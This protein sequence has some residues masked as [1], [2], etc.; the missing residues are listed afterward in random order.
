MRNGFDR[1]KHLLPPRPAGSAAL[2]DGAPGADILIGWHVGFDGL[3]T[4]GGILRHLAHKPPPVRFAARRVARSDV[5]AGAAFADWLDSAWL[6][7]DRDVQ[8]MMET[9]ER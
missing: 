5:P 3:D 9:D 4:F 1:C 7:A 6:Q 2:I 8:R